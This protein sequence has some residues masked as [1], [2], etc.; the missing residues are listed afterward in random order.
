VDDYLITSDGR[1]IGRISSAFRRPTVHSGQIVQDEPGHAYVLIRPA[2]G[3]SHADR[4]AIR[5][6]ILD[7]I[8]KFAVELIETS[9]IPKTPRGKTALVIR[10]ADQ[11]SL[12]S[13]YREIIKRERSSTVVTSPQSLW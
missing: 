2:E 11:P 7:R 3:Y 6:S 12:K 8:G 1:K 10:L 4:I 9:E 13:V 5:D